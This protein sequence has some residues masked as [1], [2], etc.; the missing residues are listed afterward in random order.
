MKFIDFIKPVLMDG[1]HTVTVTQNVT[2]PQTQS[3]AQSEPFYV[4][5]KAYTLDPNDVFSVSPTENECGDFS[6]L[7][8]FITIENK[9][10][11]WERKITAD[12]QRVPVP[13]V[14]L[15]V[16]SATENTEEGDISVADLLRY[17]PAATYFPSQNQLPKIVIE[18]ES[19]VCHVVDLSKELYHAIMPTYEEMIYLTHIRR[20]NLAHTEDDIIEKDGDFSVIMANRFI[21]T[22]IN[23]PLKSTVHLVSMLG[24]PREIPSGYDKVRLVSLHRWNTYSVQDNS[25]VFQQLIDTLS[26]N[27]G[28]IGCNKDNEVLKRCYVPKK[29]M[30]RSGETTVSLYRPP[31][32]PYA[33]KEIDST[34]K[35]TAD[36]HL[37]YDPKNGIFDTSYA[38]AF[39]LGR[40]ISLHRKADSERID[41]W[42]KNRKAISHQRLLRANIGRIDVVEL[43]RKMS[44]DM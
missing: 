33:N 19:D 4:A 29:H 30:T 1:E 38:A 28:M 20:V 41:A 36:G 15:I 12:I 9:T 24:M 13:W 6:K 34:S 14:A 8:P 35:Y 43:C 40:L 11:P 5:G 39:Q 32:I 31:L 17:T 2:A 22:G 25:Q 37:I 23:E 27:T 44:E 10:F 18:K 3:F 42:R 26:S 7:L 21:P 16:L